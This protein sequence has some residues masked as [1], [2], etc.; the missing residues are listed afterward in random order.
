MTIDPDRPSEESPW[1]SPSTRTEPSA[2]ELAERPSDRAGDFADASGPAD[3]Q[4]MRLP[5]YQPRRE[6]FLGKPRSLAILIA[7]GVVLGALA[8]ALT[9]MAGGGPRQ[10]PAPTFPP[11]AS[12]PASTAT[13]ADQAA[14]T[15]RAPADLCQ[16]ADFTDL[17]PPFTTIGDLNPHAST[18]ATLAIAGCDGTTG[19]DAVNGNFAFE[20]QVSSRPDALLDLFHQQRAA[21]AARVA[22]TP[23][24]GVGAEAFQYAA[25]GQHGLS[26]DVYDSNLI[27]R[28]SWT[29]MHTNDRLPD[30]LATALADTCRSTLRLLRQ[31]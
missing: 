22:V 30:D 19:N 2:R 8:T 20:V 3:A 5:M 14:G 24:S 25:V 12:P 31:A 23:V 13:A 9:V 26:I 17:R 15:Y 4:T 16:D 27:M 21:L 18:T 29:A 28:L 7:V 10:L 11:T 1:S 6:P